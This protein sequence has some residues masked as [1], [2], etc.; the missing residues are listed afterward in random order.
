MSQVAELDVEKL[1]VGKYNVRRELG[2]ISELV[3]SVK[4]VGILE[5]LIV[6]S[7]PNNRYEVIV[8]NRRYNAAKKAG[9]KKIPCILKEMSD[10]EAI[11]T[12]LTENIQRG[13]LA[14]QEIVEAY[15]T[16]HNIDSKRWTREAFSKQVGKSRSWISGL[17]TAYESFIKLKTRG[18]IT[19]MKAYPRDEEKKAGIAPI[20]HLEEIEYAIR[21]DEVRK[22]LSEDKVEEK[23]IELAKAVLQLPQDD[24]KRVIDRFKM[25]PEK[26]IEETKEEA[27]ARKTG[28]ALETYLPP[29]IAR[30][31]D[32]VAVERRASIE[33]IL[34]DVVERGLRAQTQAKG[35]RGEVPAKMINEF[36]V[37]EIECPKCGANLRLIHCEPGKTHKVESKAS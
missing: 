2:D 25:Y 35:E 10:D 37:G 30:E 34:P 5:P 22:T 33:E 13:D 26:P 9:L 11:M 23:R 4:Q 31:L 3:E 28:V 18:V 27:L 20:R 8:G 29:R 7:A 6:R 19:G 21:S 36:D 17:L 12:S 16:L 15:T 1:F 14:E 32:R 24:A